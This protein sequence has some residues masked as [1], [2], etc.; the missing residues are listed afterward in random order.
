MID[1][2]PCTL[3]FPGGEKLRCEQISSEMMKFTSSNGEVYKSLKNNNVVSW[4]GDVR[5]E[6][7]EQRKPQKKKL[8][9]K[10]KSKFAVAGFVILGIIIIILMDIF[11]SPKSSDLSMTKSEAYHEAQMKYH[12]IEPEKEFSF[13]EYGNGSYTLISPSC[14]IR[15]ENTVSDGV[16]LMK[17][18][19]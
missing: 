10:A 9:K 4:N 16:E 3:T 6:M 7:R 8:S 19:R 13:E 1:H 2:S 14:I 12:G 5:P 18:S 15:V 17:L 11:L